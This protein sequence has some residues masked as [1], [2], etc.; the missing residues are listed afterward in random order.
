MLF[1]IPSVLSLN[2]CVPFSTLSPSATK[3]S[4]ITPLVGAV[5]G[6]LVCK[7]NTLK[8]LKTGSVQLY[9][10]KIQRQFSIFQGM[11][12]TEVQGSA[13]FG[14]IHIC[15]YAKHTQVLCVF[16][17]HPRIYPLPCIRYSKLQHAKFLVFSTTCR[18]QEGAKRFW[19][20]MRPDFAFC[21]LTP[22][23]YQPCLFQSLQQ[24]H[25]QLQCLQQLL[26]NKD[27]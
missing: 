12:I 26:W 22:S 8:L 17:S 1:Y 19:K 6:M 10:I 27:N 21:R 15:H 13:I 9:Q 25:L 5:T 3:S 16:H 11:E 14:W 20:S 23:A 4:S 7:C 18:E 2:S 24:L